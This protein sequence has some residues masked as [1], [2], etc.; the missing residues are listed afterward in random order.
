MSDA[1]FMSMGTGPHGFELIELTLTPEKLVAT[2]LTGDPNVPA[3]MFEM[4]VALRGARGLF[5]PLLFRS[6]SN[7]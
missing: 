4:H 7:R 3:G 1:I 5:G 2:K 6:G